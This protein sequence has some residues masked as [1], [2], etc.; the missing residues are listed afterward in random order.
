MELNWDYSAPGPKTESPPAADAR[1]EAAIAEL[2]LGLQDAVDTERDAAFTEEDEF[3]R[4][5]MAER[6][7]SGL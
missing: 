6:L 1:D 2:E 3:V 4:Q 7:S 5:W